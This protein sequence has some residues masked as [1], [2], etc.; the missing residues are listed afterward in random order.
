MSFLAARKIKNENHRQ[1]IKNEN[2][3]TE[4][5]EKNK[6]QNLSERLRKLLNLE[7]F[8]QKSIKG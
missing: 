8:G 4:T 3:T 5:P 6:N 7:F 1:K 2:R